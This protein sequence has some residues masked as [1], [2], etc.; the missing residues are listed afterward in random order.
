MAYK[1]IF[2]RG[3]TVV[4]EEAIAAAAFTPGHLLERTSADKLQKHSTEDGA[5][6]KMFGIEDDLQGKEITEAYTAADQS[7]ARI[8]QRGDLVYALLANGENVSI[9]DKLVS[10]GDGTL[11][12]DTAQSSAATAE[13]SGS[14]VGFAREAV[15]MSDS[16]AADPTGRILVEIA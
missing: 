7:F 15:D 13:V 2:V 9:G 16:S 4:K 14:I 8:A 6:Q 11:K 5:C 3:D 10:K 12:K 1:T